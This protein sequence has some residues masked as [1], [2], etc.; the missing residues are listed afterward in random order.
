MRRVK[1]IILCEGETDLVLI[2]SYL[3][4]VRGWKYLKYKNPPLADET[5]SW[6]GND[7]EEILGI[8]PVGGNSFVKPI[9]KIVGLEKLEPTFESVVVVT[10]HDD[11]SAERDRLSEVFDIIDVTTVNQGKNREVCP[12]QWYH[13]EVKGDFSDGSDDDMR[14]AYLLV[15]CDEVGAL[16]TFMLDALSETSPE[17][18]NVIRQ[19]RSFVK[20]FDSNVYL[21]KRR[22]QTKAELGV[23]LAVFSPDRVFTTM[24]ELIDSVDW[25]DFKASE[26][27]FRLLL[28]I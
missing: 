8:W 22:E 26:T 23:A 28:E 7:H 15:P 24:Q 13:F 10:D 1:G 16:E 14:F 18:D 25:S 2:S 3:G 20:G 9:Q 5:V 12:N 19:S 17:R 11:L 4:K 21:K 6:Y 27:Q